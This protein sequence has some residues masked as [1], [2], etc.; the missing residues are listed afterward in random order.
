MGATKGYHP[1]SLH[2]IRGAAEFCH[3]KFGKIKKIAEFPEQQKVVYVCNVDSAPRGADDWP[4][5]VYRRQLQHCFM[6]DI[7]VTSVRLSTSGDTTVVL[8]VQLGRTPMDAYQEELS[9]EIR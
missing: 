5:K 6:D 2:V 8:T 1:I 3:F 9:N 4:P 7:R